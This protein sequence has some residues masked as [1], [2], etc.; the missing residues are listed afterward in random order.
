MSSLIAPRTRSRRDGRG[1]FTGQG[2][3]AL[4]EFALVLP[5][6]LVLLLGMLDLGKAMNYRNDLTHLSNEAARF[7]AVNK[8]PGPEA[9]L[10]ESIRSQ[11]SS[12]ELKNG[13]SPGE[14]GTTTQPLEVLICFP[15]GTNSTDYEI[16]D[17]VKAIVRSNYKFLGFLGFGLDKAITGTSTMRLEKAWAPGSS[18]YGGAVA[19]PCP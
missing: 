13:G 6:V 5:F 4:I 14:D 10:E 15:D 12:E 19:L 8:N 7:A 3:Q 16:G 1:R 9:T 18:A 2:G 11:A 17:P